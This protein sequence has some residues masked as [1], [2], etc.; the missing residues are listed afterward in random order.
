[1]L[2]FVGLLLFANILGGL[3]GCAQLQD[4]HP[5]LGRAFRLLFAVVTVVASVAYVRAVM[6]AP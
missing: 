4:T 1:M 6:V 3:L 2:A 5:R